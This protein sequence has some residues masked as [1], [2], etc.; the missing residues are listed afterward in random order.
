MSG[1]KPGEWTGTKNVTERNLAR[2]I[3]MADNHGRLTGAG[4]EVAIAKARIPDDSYNRLVAL[5]KKCRTAM[6]Q[7]HPWPT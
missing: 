3:A 1:V 5:G 7:E 4:R 2:R 6:N